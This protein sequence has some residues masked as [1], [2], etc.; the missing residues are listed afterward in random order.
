MLQ[1]EGYDRHNSQRITAMREEKGQKL[2]FGCLPCKNKSSD[3]DSMLLKNDI[4]LK[5]NFWFA[6]LLRHGFQVRR[7][8]QSCDARQYLQ[9]Q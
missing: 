5:D 4:P 3:L 8:E 6:Q 1:T 7:L 2:F 9:Q